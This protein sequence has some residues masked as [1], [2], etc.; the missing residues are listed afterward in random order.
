MNWH[1]NPWFQK[2]YLI[3]LYAC[4]TVGEVISLLCRCDYSNNSF[5]EHQAI[6]A[7]CGSGGIAPCV[8]VIGTT[9]RWVDSFT[10]RPIYSPE[11]EPL[12]PSP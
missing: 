12:V 5:T 11:K 2:E 9:W 6:K 3:K 7:Y 10:H 1:C 8:L 4:M